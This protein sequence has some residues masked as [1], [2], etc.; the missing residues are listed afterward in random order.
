M[1]RRRTKKRETWHARGRRGHRTNNPNRIE[2]FRVFQSSRRSP[3]ACAARLLKL[4]KELNLSKFY[5]TW[6]HNLLSNLP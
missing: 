4:A 2:R 6:Q 1:S 3:E 5:E